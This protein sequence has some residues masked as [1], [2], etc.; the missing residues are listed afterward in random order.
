MAVHFQ[1]DGGPHHR[2]EVIT[3]CWFPDQIYVLD[4]QLG[5]LQTN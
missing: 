1:L 5:K 3:S 2:T 4:L